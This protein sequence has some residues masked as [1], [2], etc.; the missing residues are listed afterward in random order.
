MRDPIR[1]TSHMNEQKLLSAPIPWYRTRLFWGV[2]I[3]ILATSNIGLLFPI[4]ET[5][6]SALDLSYNIFI[7]LGATPTWMLLLAFFGDSTLVGIGSILLYG[8]ILLLLLHK[9]FATNHAVSIIYPLV[10]VVNLLLTTAL[11]YIGF[12]SI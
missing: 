8:M 12:S 3:G 11:L 6:Q 4:L 2:V 5:S 9:T 1:Y 10:I 7:I